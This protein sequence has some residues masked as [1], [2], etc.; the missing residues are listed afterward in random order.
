ML[1]TTNQLTIIVTIFIKI[2]ILFVLH[3]FIMLCKSNYFIK[4]VAINQI[5]NKKNNK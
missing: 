3:A 1:Y 4:E 2:L 5:N